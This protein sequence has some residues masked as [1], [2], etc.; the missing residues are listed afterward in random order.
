MAHEKHLYVLPKQG[1]TTV[2]R[3]VAGKRV[4]CKWVSPKEG[5][6]VDISTHNSAYKFDDFDVLALK[7]VGKIYLIPPVNLQSSIKG[8]L[9]RNIYP[10]DYEEFIDNWS[11]FNPGYEPPTPPLFEVYE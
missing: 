6:Y 1:Q 8:I 10:R 9:K 2:D 7:T 5:G 11:I 4:Q 3:V